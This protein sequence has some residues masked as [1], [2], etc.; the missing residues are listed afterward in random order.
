MNG[1]AMTVL[2]PLHGPPATSDGKSEVVASN[3]ELPSLQ[4]VVP[5]V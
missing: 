3:V 4:Q 5:K 2:L 1:A